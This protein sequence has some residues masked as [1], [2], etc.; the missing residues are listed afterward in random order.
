MGV[1]QSKWD[2]DNAA[3]MLFSD[4]TISTYDQDVIVCEVNASCYIRRYEK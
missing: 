1:T 3:L 2:D 4:R